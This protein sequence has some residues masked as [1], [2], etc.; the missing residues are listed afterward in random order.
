MSEPIVDVL[1]VGAGPSGLTVALQ[2]ANLGAGVRIVDRRTDAFRPSRAIIV[3]ARTL[4]VLRPLG[5]TDAIVARGEAAPT[6]DLHLGRRVVR[7]RLGPFAIADTPFPFLAF[8][9]QAVV[10]EELAAALAELGVDVEWGVELTDLQAGR[11]RAIAVLGSA[12][13]RTEQVAARFVAGCDGLAS[14]VR[15]SVD[16][17]RPGEHYRHEIVLA[18]VELDTALA[19]HVGHM[20]VG[21]TGLLFLLAMAEQATWRVLATRQHDPDARPGRA[22]PEGDVQALIDEAGLD[23]TVTDLA[24]SNSVPLR[25][26]LAAH[27]R[28]GPLFLVGDAAH[29]HSPAGGQGMNTGIQDAVNLGWKL[30]FASQST[31]TNGQREKLLDSYEAERRPVARRML[32]ATRAL[33]WGEAGTD[34]VARFARAAIGPRAATLLPVLLRRRRVVAA[35]VRWLSQLQVAY[36]HSAVSTS[37]TSSRRRNPIRAGERLPDQ[38]LTE[39]GVDRLHELVAR[40]G[41]QVLLHRDAPPIEASLVG[42]WTHV[43]RIAAW[44]GEGVVVVRPDAYVGYDSATADPERI[45]SWLASI[46]VSRP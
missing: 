7:T 18:D 20:A 2:A 32:A 27:Y 22:V 15:H 37:A 43:H 31:A 26:R 10:E 30:A 42:P 1:V 33:F 46:G 17:D 24:W 11:E 13:G 16:D 45:L 6:V 29:T 14:I 19:P 28:N 3:H 12:D 39:A 4:E 40:P 41:V 38:A 8:V 21:R 9:P 35:G 36:R 5:V 25:H 34:P 44:P 23:A